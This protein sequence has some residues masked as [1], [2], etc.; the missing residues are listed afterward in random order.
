MSDVSCLEAAVVSVEAS[1]LLEES[2]PIEI[3]KQS[4][5]R[6]V[7]TKDFLLEL[8]FSPQSLVK[9]PHLPNLSIICEEVSA[10][11]SLF[12]VFTTVIF[13]RVTWIGEENLP[14]LPWRLTTIVP[15]PLVIVMDPVSGRKFPTIGL[16]GLDKRLNVQSEKAGHDSEWSAFIF[17]HIFL[18]YKKSICDES[19][20]RS[21]ISTAIA[22]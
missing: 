5:Q 19:N 17:E 6:I 4:S 11:Y 7:Y 9:P 12:H 21:F 8:R 18:N 22:W 16:Q 20:K 3:P 10:S 14:L 2:S 15:D 13:P 1:P